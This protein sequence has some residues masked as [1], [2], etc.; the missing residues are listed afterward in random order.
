MKHSGFLCSM[1]FTSKIEIFDSPLWKYHLKVP[2]EVVE[3]FV[4]KK[5]VK[6]VQCT[7]NDSHTFQ[8][9]LMPAGGGIYF[10][11]LNQQIRKK[12]R[13]NPGDN[14]R[15]ELREDDSPYGLPMPEEFAELLAQDEESN[16]LFHALTP[17]KQRNLLYIIGSPKTA[18]TRLRRALVCMEHL[19]KM[20]G[21]I[22]FKLLNEDLKNARF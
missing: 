2:E 15:V 8:C 22:D 18:D 10:I 12:L 21:K 4:K 19:K 13:L 5:K 20:N 11:N 6:R 14:V 17:G 9:A 7:L 1:T 3:E 16:R